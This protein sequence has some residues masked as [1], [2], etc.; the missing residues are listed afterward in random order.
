MAINSEYRVNEDGSVTKIYNGSNNTENNRKPGGSSN[1]NGCI[2]LGIIVI[3]IGVLIAIFAVH[4]SDSS[5]TNEDADSTVESV[6]SVAEEEPE[7][8][9]VYTP[10]TTYLNVSDDDIYMSADG[11]STEISISTDGEWYIDVDVTS[12]GHLT[13]SSNSVT[14]QLD[15]N[16][17]SS[18]RTDY[19]VIKS[20]NY[21]KRVNITQGGDMSPKANIEN[22][23][24]DHNVYQNNYKGMKIHVKFTV[25]NMNG[26][27]IYAYAFF[28]WGNNTTPL[29]DQNGNNL[30]F[31]NYGTPSYDNARYDDL[32]IF[33]PYAGL[34]MQ[35]GQGSVS[36]SFDISIR[37][38]S[39]SELDRNDNTQFTL[40]N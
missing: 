16:N 2:W 17:S 3:V 30:S 36:L 29:H 23:W 6:D 9:E 13:K 7:V 1:N 14:L 10:S 5:Y 32:V 20:G 34:N 26:K 8:E 22:I 11:G 21:T 18:S 25:E 19:F 40:S 4:S 37:T 12:W 24:V 27:T 39:G 38:S 28:Y 33:V 31:Y 15:E 35:P